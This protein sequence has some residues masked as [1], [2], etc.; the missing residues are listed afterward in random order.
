VIAV[1]NGSDDDSFRILK[2]RAF[3]LPMMVLSEPRRGK[4]IALNAGLAYVEGK[5]VALTDDDV[6][7]PPD[8]LTT[9]ESITAHEA[10]YDIFGGAIYPVWEQ[11]PP[12]WVLRCVPKAM[13]SCTDF[14]QGPISPF[15]VWGPSMA[16][17]SSVFHEY[18]FAENIGPNGSEVYVM[19]SETEFTCRAA[20]SGHRCW[21]FDAAPVGHMIRPH[22]LTPDWALQRAYNLARGERRLFRMGGERRFFRVFG[23]PLRYVFGFIKAYGMLAA[24]ACRLTYARLFGDFEDRIRASLRLRYRQGDLAERYAF[25]REAF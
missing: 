2:E 16:V 1:D 22:Q 18:K 17:R 8:W 11:T 14:A 21:H 5:I 19:G 25:E 4:N 7:L 3:K 6:L 23:Y 15:N 10:D 13:Y 20:L 12:D 24:A 9:I